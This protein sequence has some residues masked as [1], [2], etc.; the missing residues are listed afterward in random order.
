[1]EVIVLISKVVQ[2]ALLDEPFVVKDEFELPILLFTEQVNAK[3]VVVKIVHLL[4]MLHE[5]LLGIVVVSIKLDLSVDAT[6]LP[7]SR[8]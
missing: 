4:E 2:V 6:L 5:G 8:N 7:K 1:M 3:N